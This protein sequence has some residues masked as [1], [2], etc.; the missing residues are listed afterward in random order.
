MMTHGKLYAGATAILLLTLSWSTGAA[1]PEKPK[2]AVV[3]SFSVEAFG[4]DTVQFADL[5]GDG[6]LELLVLQSAG[7]FCSKLYKGQK[8]LDEVDRELYCLTAVTL[9]GKVLWQ[10][11]TPYKRDFPFTSHGA[12]GGELMLSVSDINADGKPEIAVIRHGELALLEAATGKTLKSVKLPTDNFVDLSTAQFGPPGKGRQII[13]KVN[14]KA[15]K[16]W[17]YGNP[18]IV[19]NAD[20]SVYHE[21]FDVPGAGHNW[22]VR[23]FNGDGRD[24]LLMGYSLLDHDLQTV[25]KLDLGPG[26][27]YAAEHADHIGVSDLFGDGQQVVRYAG[28]KDFFVTD[29]KGKII[30]QTTAGHSQQSVA[31]PWG[32]QGEQHIVMS[33]KNRGLWGLDTAGKV[34][35][36]SKDLNGYAVASVRWAKDGACRDWALFRPQLKPIKR[37]PYESD[38]AQSRTLWPKFLASDGTPLD[39]LP[40]KDE[41]AQPKRLI[42]AERSYDCGVKYY[43]LVR[44]LD[45]DGLDEVLVY[46]RSR[47]WL[48]HAPP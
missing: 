9:E 40:W 30:W 22:V 15:Y 32:P 27:D 17:H 5:Y 37:T 48:F 26:F 2:E 12:Q 34:R 39:V 1:E 14:D 20:L 31:G 45:H 24:E 13:C 42:R 4:G 16:P 43:A 19:Y 8:D 47:V 28:S 23:D 7:Q 33:E 3:R 25:W 46:D 35:W 38:P 36:H 29:L 11:G 44:D 18:I 41:Y 6:K 21:P 10:D